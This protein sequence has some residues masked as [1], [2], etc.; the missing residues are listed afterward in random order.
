MKMKCPNCGKQME[1]GFLGM[2]M[3]LN[4]PKWFQEKSK[5]GTGG[6]KLKL[7]DKLGMVYADA[8]RCKEC[9]LMTIK[10]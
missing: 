2:E 10:Y 4:G 1:T 6:E 3:F 8:H 7:K 9:K 5:L